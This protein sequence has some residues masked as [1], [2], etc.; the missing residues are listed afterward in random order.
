VAV[1]VEGTGFGHGRGM[2]QWGAY[3]WAVDQDKS[4]QWILDHYYGGTTLGDVDTSQARIRVRLLGLDNLT[5]VGVTAGSGNV[6][7]QGVSGRSMYAREISP[8]RFELY[9]T[10]SMA[11]PAS[12]TL[13]VPDGP[14]ARGSSN[15]TAV[16]QIQ[17]FLNA[18]RID[19]DITLTVDGAFGPLTELRVRDWQ[20]D[21]NL[22]VDGIWNSDDAT[23]ARQQISSAS[24]ST[25]W[26]F[27]GR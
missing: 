16:R 17:T 15:S 21:Q 23:R 11:C 1:V 10:T 24:G 13:V 3:G 25:T 18:F 4:W 2:S 7:A 26:T 9:S 22:V 19:G 20:S 27:R 12:A 6:T 14:I 5:T 8:N